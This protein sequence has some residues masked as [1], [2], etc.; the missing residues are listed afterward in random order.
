MEELD[1]EI[2]GDPESFTA[3][4]QWLRETSSNIEQAEQSYLKARGSSE[5]GWGGEAGDA[6][7]EIAF[8]GARMAG[9]TVQTISEVCS[10]MEIHADG[11]RTATAQ[12]QQARDAA[13]EGGL[14][15]TGFKIQPPGDAPAAPAPLPAGKQASPQQTQDHAAAVAAQ[16][17]YKR[18]VEAYNEAAGLVAKAKK[19][20]TDSQNAIVRSIA[21]VVEP[22]KLSLTLGDVSTGLAGAVTANASKWKTVAAN[23]KSPE[24]PA[25]LAQN[26]T[27]SAAGRFRAAEIAAE[28]STAK[29]TALA[30]AY[31]TRIASALDKLPDWAKY[32]LDAKII[33]N[34]GATPT[35]PI[36]K[37]ATKLGRTLPYTGLLFTA[38]G[39]GY[40]IQ[41]GKDPTQAVVSG[42]ASFVAGAASGAAIGAAFGGPIGVV[43]GAIIGIGV[44]IAVDEGWNLFD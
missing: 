27:M 38:A 11:L 5:G 2:K 12:M 8:Q 41:Q 37:G 44:G 26:T 14:T 39:V 15:I 30:N 6:F 20:E 25:K 21:G 17:A 29:A 19:T 40:D 43:G 24:L 36:L 13:T 22:V 16:A 42:G 3:T 9:D 34:G 28:R 35:S 33:P 1:T 10:A 18:K 31:P 4:C 7:R 32:G 23:V